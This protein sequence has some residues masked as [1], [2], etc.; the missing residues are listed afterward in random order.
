MSEVYDYR[1]HLQAAKR[2]SKMDTGVEETGGSP[3]TD[4]RDRPIIADTSPC[5]VNPYQNEPEYLAPDKDPA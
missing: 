2:W 3:A 1:L 4:R 5:E